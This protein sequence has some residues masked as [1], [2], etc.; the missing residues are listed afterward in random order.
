MNTSLKELLESQGVKADVASVLLEAWEEKISEARQQIEE[1]VRDEMSKRYEHDKGQLVESM[2]KFLKEHL[3]REVQLFSDTK[4]DIGE[5][6]SANQAK[7]AKRVDEMK[8]S[9]TETLK[10]E[11]ETIA[12]EK[13]R[14]AQ[15]RAE[16]AKIT[17]TA[18][19]QAK[20]KSDKQLS[21]LTAFVQ[22]KLAE[23]LAE[24]EQDKKELSEERIKLHKDL[25]EAR[26]GYKTAF[27][28][29]AKVLEQFVL[30]QLTEEIGEFEEDKKLL[31]QRR[32]QLETQAK[33]KIQETQK[34]FIKKAS[35]I[36][37][38]TMM[39]SMNTEMTRLKEDLKVA[40]ENNFGRRIFESFAAE[41]MS[42]YLAEGSEIR[43]LQKTLT[44]AK[45]AIAESQSKLE[46]KEKELSAATRKIHLA[47]GRAERSRILNELLGPLSKSQRTVMGN[48]LE[49][50][51]T[52]KLNESFKRYLP[53]VLKETNGKTTALQGKKVLNENETK[54][55]AKTVA[56]T[57]DRA[58]RLADETKDNND[59]G[60]IELRKLAGL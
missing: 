38:D 10:K 47:E 2:D 3:A 50:V 39:K 12:E 6:A 7:L 21:T 34:A 57:G 22:K 54:E 59:Q 29:R 23:E 43:S 30:R 60:V 25:R 17:E 48:L 36:V 46:L 24:F 55:K 27:A 56:V 49:S 53:T 45:K 40:R 9:V 44:E 33:Q 20:A 26:L 52:E 31:E 41:Y 4:K 58:N 42:S 35:R 51:K 37:E 32:V 8:A 13:E 1:Q 5:K 18:A 14:L 15:Q 11:L 16:L 28:D 19:A